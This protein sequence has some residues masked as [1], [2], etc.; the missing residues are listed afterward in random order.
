MGYTS[1]M[2]INDQHLSRL[3][4][5][6][7]KLAGSRAAADALRYSV[8]LTLALLIVQSGW[9]LWRALQPLPAIAAPALAAAAAASAPPR[10]PGSLA[11]QIARHHLF[12]IAAV[13]AASAPAPKEKADGPV[14]VLGIVFASDAALSRAIL[15]V[16]GTQKSYATGA[17]L[18]NGDV[19]AAIEVDRAILRQ[20]DRKYAVVLKH[21]KAGLLTE[22]PRFDGTADQAAAL[23]TIVAAPSAQPVKKPVVRHVAGTTLQRLSALRARLLGGSSS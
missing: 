4:G 21:P 16:G 2:R 8:M 6:L 12:G 23:A 7:L 18:P 9:G 10:S 19:L 17:T 11:T 3:R 15:A 14:K 5:A 13:G 20:R 22:A 1:P